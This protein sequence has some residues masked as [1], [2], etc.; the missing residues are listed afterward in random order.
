MKSSP[1][2]DFFHETPHKKYAAFH[3]QSYLMHQL[4]SKYF[5]VVL[6]DVLP[7]S[8]F[9]TRFLLA[10]PVRPL[11]LMRAPPL[12]SRGAEALE[13]EERRYDLSYDQPPA[14]V[15]GN[16][17][18]VKYNHHDPRAHLQYTVYIST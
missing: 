17:W 2:L 6:S 13:K 11:Q 8:I 5:P 1:V 9:Q 10:P 15:G 4:P 12:H 16:T 14:R 3:E 18:G 7:S